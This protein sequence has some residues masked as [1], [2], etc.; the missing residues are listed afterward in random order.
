MDLLI[1]QAINGLAGRSALLD[2]IMTVLAEWLAYG[3]PLLLLGLWF[4]PGPARTERR[5][6]AVLTAGAMLLSLGM[7]DLPG[8]VYFRPRPFESHEVTLLVREPLLP[9]FPSTHM[10]AMSAMF[11]GVGEHLGR[12]QYLAWGVAAG[13]MLARVYV[14][15]HY[16]LDVAA[17]F[18][19]G[20]VVGLVVMQNRD[21]LR[22]FALRLISFAEELL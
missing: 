19:D 15:V 6:T 8:L 20:L 4:L 14:G 2:F 3:A 11:V 10:A 17:G 1:F 7:A 5:I 13:S 22:D 21:A 9:S 18:L 12:W 16:P